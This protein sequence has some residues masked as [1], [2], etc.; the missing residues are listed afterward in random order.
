[1]ATALRNST[2]VLFLISVLASPVLSQDRVLTLNDVSP[3]LGQLI[4][5]TPLDFVAKEEIKYGV[6]GKSEYDEFFKSSAVAHGGFVVGSGLADDATMNL[7][8]YARSKAA[9]AE[10]QEEIAELTGGADT[11]EWTIEHSLAVLGAAEK[12][13]Q[14]SDEERAYMVTTAAH[15]AASLVVVTSAVSASKDLTEQAPGLVSGARSAFGMRGAAGASRN[16][17]RSA[18]RIKGIPTEG[19]A[20]MESLVVLSK[21]LAMLSGN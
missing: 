13:D 16:V 12:K 5:G 15:I 20:L 9:V 14:L 4:G 10:L 7:K 21:G 1:M 6:T 2:P 19:P 17:Q 3:E 11:S 8:K 18:D